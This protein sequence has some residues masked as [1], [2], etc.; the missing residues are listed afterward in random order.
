MGILKI[1]RFVVKIIRSFVYITSD[2]FPECDRLKIKNAI[3]QCVG[4]TKRYLKML[5]SYIDALQHLGEGNPQW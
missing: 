4:G 1:L 2:I 5:S 3:K